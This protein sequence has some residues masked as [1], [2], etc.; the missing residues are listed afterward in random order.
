MSTQNRRSKRRAAVDA[1][2]KIKKIAD[3]ETH[4]DHES[5]TQGGD[6][7][8]SKNHGERK[9]K[10]Y[11]TT[12]RKKSSYFYYEDNDPSPSFSL[13]NSSFSLA[14]L[15]SIP[16]GFDYLGSTNIASVM[17]FSSFKE[18][19]K[20]EQLNSIDTAVKEELNREE[21]RRRRL[22]N[23]T[24]P[25]EMSEKTYHR[26]SMY[27]PQ[28]PVHATKLCFSP[29]VHFPTTPMHVYQYRGSAA[30]AP[31]AS[32]SVL[33]K[34]SALARRVRPSGSHRGRLIEP[35]RLI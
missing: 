15:S 21:R 33:R 20:E 26:L 18:E 29:F 9:R 4:F 30:A 23:S 2:N 12:Q 32:T 5:Q 22:I 19:H 10:S 24:G 35:R 8:N 25:M 31:R 13:P 11:A 16:E 7:S 6:T 3:D 28:S 27:S 34:K 17:S 14:S 1:A